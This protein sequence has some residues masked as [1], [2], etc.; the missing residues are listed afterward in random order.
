MRCINAL[1]DLWI[2][3]LVWVVQEAECP[4]GTLDIL[5]RVLGGLEAKGGEMDEALGATGEAL[6]A[7]RRWL[8]F[9]LLSGLSITPLLVRLL[10]LGRLCCLRLLLRLLLLIKA[11]LPLELLLL[12]RGQSWRGRGREL[13][14]R[15]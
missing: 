3:P 9:L 7:T 12:L 8:L 11:P 10:A 13:G 4:V 2:A 5:L 15:L 14:L 1:T 6:A